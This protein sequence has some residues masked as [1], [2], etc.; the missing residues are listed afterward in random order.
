MVFGCNDNEMISTTQVVIETSVVR[1]V[2]DK[3]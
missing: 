1:L 3:E 2:H